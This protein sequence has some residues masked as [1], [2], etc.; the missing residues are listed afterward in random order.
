MYLKLRYNRA[1]LIKIVLKMIDDDDAIKKK[2]K[3]EKIRTLLLP[4]RYTVVLCCILGLYA[5]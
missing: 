1:K 5:M 4:K 3:N 2:M